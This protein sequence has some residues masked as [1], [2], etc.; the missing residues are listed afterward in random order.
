MVR[1]KAGADVEF[2]NKLFLAETAQGLI[3]DWELHQDKVPADTRLLKPSVE[4]MET[5]LHIE[6]KYVGTDRGF[7]SQENRQ[8]LE[9]EELFNGVCPRDP[10]LLKQRLQE[11]KFVALQKRRSQTE[12]RIGI[13]KNVFLGRPMKAKGFENRQR[14][15]AWAV[16]AHNLW[17]LVRMEWKEEAITPQEKAA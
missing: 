10:A 4:R 7:D 17:V 14:S 16:M 2:G 11:V 5:R 3:V 13:F 12:G 8:F 1:R 15:L 6:I 9:R